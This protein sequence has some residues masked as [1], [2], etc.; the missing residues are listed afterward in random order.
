MLSN[1]QPS[2]VNT[3]VD[4]AAARHVHFMGIKGVGMTALALCVQDLGLAVSGSDVVEDFVT[5]DLLR[6]RNIPITD[7][8]IAN[9]FPPQTGCLI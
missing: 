8:N 3:S 4:L 7:V 9:S 2:Q 1:A 5:T 6:V